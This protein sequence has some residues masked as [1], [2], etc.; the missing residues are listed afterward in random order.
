MNGALTV[1]LDDGLLGPGLGQ[2]RRRRLEHTH[3][4]ATIEH[5]PIYIISCAS[6]SINDVTSVGLSVSIQMNVCLV[7]DAP[8]IPTDVRSG[9][10]YL[11][12]RSSSAMAEDGLRRLTV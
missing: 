7:L 11:A 5:R 1:L 3:G 10:A 4:P 9:R 6:F 2:L 8:S 12:V